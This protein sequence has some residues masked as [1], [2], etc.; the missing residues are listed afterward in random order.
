MV[1]I[2]TKHTVLTAD[3]QILNGKLVATP[4]MLRN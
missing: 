3:T 2:D 4:V 1:L